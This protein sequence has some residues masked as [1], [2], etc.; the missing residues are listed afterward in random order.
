MAASVVAKAKAGKPVEARKRGSR[1]SR[2]NL[3]G[4]LRQAGLYF[5]INS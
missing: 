3:A 1:L 5:C 2:A 4:L